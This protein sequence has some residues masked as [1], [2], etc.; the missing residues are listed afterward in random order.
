MCTRVVSTGL[1]QD[2]MFRVCLLG[3]VGQHVEFYS[4]IKPMMMMMMPAKR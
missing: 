3:V 1:D 4:Q 2:K